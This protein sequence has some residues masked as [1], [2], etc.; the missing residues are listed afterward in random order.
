MLLNE[1][2]ILEEITH[3]SIVRVYKLLEDDTHYF[4]IFELMKHGDLSD[5]IVKRNST[6]CKK[7]K[8]KEMEIKIIA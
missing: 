6:R 1:L 2:S 4:I 3:P 8:M 7:G 5:Y